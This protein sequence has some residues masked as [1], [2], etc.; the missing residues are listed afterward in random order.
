MR[1]HK[2]RVYP[3]QS[4]PIRTSDVFARAVE[5]SFELELLDVQQVGGEGGLVR[6][7][8]QGGEVGVDERLLARHSLVRIEAQQL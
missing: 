2:G 1:S 3:I 4:H 6:L 7:A 8:V 5:F